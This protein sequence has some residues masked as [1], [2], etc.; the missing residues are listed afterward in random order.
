MAK[1]NLK[2][3]VYQN[4]KHDKPVGKNLAIGVITHDDQEKLTHCT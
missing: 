4:F 2:K 3:G 1:H